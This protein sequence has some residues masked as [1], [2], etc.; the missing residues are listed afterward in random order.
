MR[1]LVSRSLGMRLVV[2]E[3]EALVAVEWEEVVSM[4]LVVGR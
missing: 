4:V 2:K 1:S 3:G